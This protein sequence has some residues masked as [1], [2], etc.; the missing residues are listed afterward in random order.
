MEQPGQVKDERRAGRWMSA[1]IMFILV[2]GVLSF[3]W[4]ARS[5][6]LL[7]L[8]STQGGALDNIFYVILALTGIS[9]VIVHLFMGVALWRFPARPGTRAAHWHEHLGAELTW[10]IIPAVA[11][12]ILGVVGEVVWAKLYSPPPA[13]AQQVEVVGR[14]FEWQ[15]RYPG[16]DGKFG[17][18]DPK[19]VTSGNPFGMDPADPENKQNVITINDLH[20]IL[21]RP[22]ALHITAIDVIHSFSLPNFRMK[23]DAVPGRSVEI[24]FTPDKAGAYQI[25]CAQLC[26]VGHYT[27][28]GN[29]IV[30]S[31]SAFDQWL[32]SQEK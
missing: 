2:A 32:Q 28:R 3:V 21:N 19:F 20:L 25:V 16:P 24:W 9:F 4:S 31:Q 18:A 13:N 6:W 5:Y 26:G 12:V 27:M 15:F 29:V 23:Q 30:A 7:P 22:V 10:T 17:R 14:Q 11:I 8:A 1:L